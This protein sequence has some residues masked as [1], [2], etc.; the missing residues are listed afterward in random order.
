MEGISFWRISL[1]KGH[2]FLFLPQNFAKFL[3]NRGRDTKIKE[4]NSLPKAF[5]ADQTPPLSKVLGNGWF[6]GTD[7]IFLTQQRWWKRISL[8]YS[9][10]IKPPHFRDGIWDT[11]RE[12]SVQVLHLRS[13][14]LGFLPTSNSRT[15]IA[16]RWRMPG[17][18]RLLRDTQSLAQAHLWGHQRHQTLLHLPLNYYFPLLG[19]APLCKIVP[20]INSSYLEMFAMFLFL[21][22]LFESQ[23]WLSLCTSQ[24][25]PQCAAIPVPFQ[26]QFPD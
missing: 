20:Q 24:R 21:F 1:W 5:R 16:V 22:F 6:E 14:R 17:N 12:L 23:S 15:T 9:F 13:L 11:I 3:S 25:V 4:I 10:N 2:K 26:R 19:L 8:I 7:F 18:L